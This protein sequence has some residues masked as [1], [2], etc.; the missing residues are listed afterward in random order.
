MFE[1]C[2]TSLVVRSWWKKRR[3]AGDEVREGGWR[4]IRQNQKSKVRGVPSITN[5]TP[6]ALESGG[7]QW[8]QSMIPTSWIQ[9]LDYPFPW[10]IRIY[11]CTTA[12]GIS[13]MLLF[14]LD[15]GFSTT[16]LLALLNEVILCCGC[17]WRGMETAIQLQDLW[18]HLW[19]LPTRCW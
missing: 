8:W 17:V 13:N 6:K 12:H 10:Y 18:Q 5:D 11:L 2:K 4:Q 9:T 16:A 15:Q 1:R 14:R 19:P 3:K 7:G